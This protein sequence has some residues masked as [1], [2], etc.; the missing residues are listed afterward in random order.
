MVSQP[1]LQIHPVGYG[2]PSNSFVKPRVKLFKVFDTLY[3][4]CLS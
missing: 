3:I 4:C 2:Y 1:A